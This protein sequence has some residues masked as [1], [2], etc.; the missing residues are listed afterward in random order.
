MQGSKLQ[1]SQVI[2][3]CNSHRRY[4][5]EILPIYGVKHY[6]INRAIREMGERGNVEMGGGV[7][8][9]G[10]GNVECEKR[11]NSQKSSNRALCHVTTTETMLGCG[12]HTE[13]NT[14]R[15]K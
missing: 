4:M 3:L 8:G 1:T 11:D 6:S 10:G 12:F 13:D 2:T 9:G 5:D 7:W 14:D 15:M